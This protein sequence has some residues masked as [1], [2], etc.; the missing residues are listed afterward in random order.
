V[1]G[2][3]GRVI[4]LFDGGVATPVEVAADDALDD[5]MVSAG[6]GADTFRTPAVRVPTPC[7][8]C[9]CSREWRRPES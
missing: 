6:G 5:E 4:L 9:P 2:E 7:P 3:Q 8:L 1:N